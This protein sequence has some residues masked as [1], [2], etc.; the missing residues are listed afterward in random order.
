MERC[1]LATAD[2]HAQAPACGREDGAAGREDRQKSLGK[3]GC[4]KQRFLALK[5]PRTKWLLHLRPNFHAVSIKE[6]SLFPGE[7]EILLPPNMEFKVKSILDC[8]HG[9]TEVQCEQLEEDDPLMDFYEVP[10]R[11]RARVLL[12]AREKTGWMILF[13]WGGIQEALSYRVDWQLRELLWWV[14]E[15]PLTSLQ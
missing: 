13:F 9:L 7:Y 8:G 3:L 2:G 1:H 12:A 4:S 11:R 5:G 15:I 6:F 10:G 14:L